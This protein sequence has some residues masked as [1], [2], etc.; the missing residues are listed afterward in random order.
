MDL[1]SDN[2][3]KL[4]IEQLQKM[5]GVGPKSAQRLAFFFLSLPEKQVEIFANTLI[6]TKRQVRF[7]ET[8]F[9]ITIEPKCAI[10]KDENRQS[11]TI[12]VVAEPKDIFAIERTKA[13]KGKYHVLG[14]LISPIDGIHPE[15]LRIKELCQRIES[16]QVSEIVLAI[17]PTI[18]GDTTALYLSNLLKN[19]PVKV[20]KLAHGLP[21]GSDIDYADDLTLQK[22]FLGRQ[23]I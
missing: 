4:C 14:G 6:Q 7:C 22:A 13:F 12:A 3:L 19:Y 21:M 2:P 18:E 15:V 5:P 10:C 16:E 17:N 20:A 11:T 9:N 23:H 8:C 1:S